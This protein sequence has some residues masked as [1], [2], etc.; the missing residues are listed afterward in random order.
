MKFGAHLL[1]LCSLITTCPSRADDIEAYLHEAGAEGA[2]VQLVMDLGDSSIDTALCTFPHTCRPPFMS[3]AAFHHLED[4][5]HEGES[6]TAPG[7]F[8][9]VLSAVLE[10]SLLD[11]LSLSILISNHQDNPADDPASALGDGTLLMGYRRLQAHRTEII[12]TLK[13]LPVPAL[14]ASHTLQPRETYFEWLR[15]LAGGEVTLGRNTVGNFGSAEP[16]PDYDH[17]IIEND[18]YLTPFTKPSQCPRLYSL[19]F[20]LGSPA[21]DQDLDVELAARWPDLQQTTFFSQLLAYLRRESTDLLP[22][23]D[24]PV[25]LRQAWVVS[26]RQCA[27]LRHRRGQWV[28]DVCR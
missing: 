15:Y 18:Y 17:G 9:A 11:N 21:R 28:R 8:K 24:A 1:L 2:F 5:Y 27:G 22:Q 26:S 12:D 25:P 16:Q 10:N 3:Q 4:M 23:T 6:V 7:I 19:L 13:S 14:Q 20:T